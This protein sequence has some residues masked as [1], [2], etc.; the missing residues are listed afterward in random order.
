MTTVVPALGFMGKLLVTL[1]EPHLSLQHTLYM[2][3]R[4]ESE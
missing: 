4:A 1:F 3:R 2:V